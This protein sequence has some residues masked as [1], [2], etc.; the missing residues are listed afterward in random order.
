MRTDCPKFPDDFFGC[1][2]G[3]RLGHR[4]IRRHEA[5][6]RLASDEKSGMRI[7][8]YGRAPMP[9]SALVGNNRILGYVGHF[10]SEHR[11]RANWPA[12]STA[13]GTK[14]PVVRNAAPQAAY[15]QGEPQGPGHDA[16]S[17][18]ETGFKARVRQKADL[19]KSSLALRIVRGFCAAWKNKTGKNRLRRAA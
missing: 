7:R 10:V 11:P 19:T 2:L 5:S 13:A 3:I 12:M 4:I 9:R 17:A 6:C 14:M 18:T 16:T 15:A 1:K 8:G